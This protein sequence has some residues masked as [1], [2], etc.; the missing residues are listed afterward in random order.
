MSLKV[1]LDLICFSDDTNPHIRDIWE[2]MKACF[3][4]HEK[5]F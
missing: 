1:T 5:I 4:Y 3:E 2:E